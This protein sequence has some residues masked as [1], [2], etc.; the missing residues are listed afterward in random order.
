MT[1]KAI[2]T[3]PT[4]HQAKFFEELIKRALAS[5]RSQPRGLQLP[6]KS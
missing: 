1:G 4:E 2:G 6:D 5:Y 3:N